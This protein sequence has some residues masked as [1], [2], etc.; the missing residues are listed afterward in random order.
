MFRTGHMTAAW[1]PL[2]HCSCFPRAD[3]CPALTGLSTTAA[4]PRFCR[5][6]APMSA[7]LSH[8]CFTQK[9]NLILQGPPGGRCLRR[10]LPIFPLRVH[11]ARALSACLLWG[12]RKRKGWVCGR[13]RGWFASQHAAFI[14][15]TCWEI[16]SPFPQPATPDRGDLGSCLEGKG[17]R[18]N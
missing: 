15:V 8:S 10:W 9:P 14:K 2:F 5:K 7:I 11:W 17:Y 18:R 6:Q 16:N 12:K 4:A 13:A 1:I 3:A